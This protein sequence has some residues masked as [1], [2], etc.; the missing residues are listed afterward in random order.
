MAAEK[1]RVSPFP[2]ISFD[3]FKTCIPSYTLR[4]RSSQVLEIIKKGIMQPL[5]ISLGPMAVLGY[6]KPT[7]MVWSHLLTSV[8]LVPNQG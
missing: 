7:C 6:I 3:H 4:L 2:S 1:G 5:N 8:L